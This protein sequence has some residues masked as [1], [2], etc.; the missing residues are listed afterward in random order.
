MPQACRL[1]ISPL[2]SLGEP[3]FPPLINWIRHL[4]LSTKDSLCDVLSPG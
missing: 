1:D 3:T 4:F 2:F